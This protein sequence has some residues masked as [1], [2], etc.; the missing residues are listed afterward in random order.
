MSAVDDIIAVHASL[1]DWNIWRSNEGR[2]WATRRSPLPPSQRP[3]AYAL[4]VTA[5]TS[6]LLVAKIRRQPG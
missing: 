5:D 4:T 6:R 1:P 2:W 3:D